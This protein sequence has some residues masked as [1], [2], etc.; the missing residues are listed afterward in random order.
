MPFQKITLYKPP[1]PA[2]MNSNFDQRTNQSEAALQSE[3]RDFHATERIET[4]HKANIT[5]EPVINR[6]T[7]VAVEKVEE[8]K[9]HG[10]WG[11][12]RQP[13]TK[14]LYV[15][16]KKGDHVTHEH[17]HAGEVQPLRSDRA[18]LANRSAI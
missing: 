7:D 9:E 18:D 1:F 2:I 15:D 8:V 14:K 5:Q 17:A 13:D 11:N 16:E 12:V 3:K 4:A 6:R 10:T